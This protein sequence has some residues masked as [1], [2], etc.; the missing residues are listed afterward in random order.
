MTGE[1]LAASLTRFALR[2][3]TNV[4]PHHFEVDRQAQQILNG[5]RRRFCG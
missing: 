1:T 3:A 4:V 5:H 2:R